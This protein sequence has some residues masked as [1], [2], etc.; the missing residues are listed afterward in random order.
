MATIF[1]QKDRDA[2][3]DEIL[4]KSAQKDPTGPAQQINKIRKNLDEFQL[5]STLLDWPKAV[6]TCFLTRD[7]LFLKGKAFQGM[8]DL[9]KAK[10]SYQNLFR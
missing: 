6:K 2:F 4:A 10:A 7:H 5:T 3:S 1:E 8:G 9:E